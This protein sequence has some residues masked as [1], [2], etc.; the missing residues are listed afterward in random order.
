[1]KRTVYELAGKDDRRFS[2]FC[3]RTRM[4][5]AHK[6]IDAEYE[7]CSFTEKHKV[8]FAEYDRYPVLVDGNRTVTDSWDIACYLEDT[9]PDRPSL[10]NG[11][12]G[13]GMARFV[14]SWTDTQLHPA[15]LRTVIFD[16][17]QHVA[18]ADIDY[19]RKDREA[20]FGQTLEEMRDQQRERA[21]EL[22][23]VLVPLR[24]VLAKQDWIS[25]EAPAYGDYIVFGALQWPRSISPFPVVEPGDPVHAWRDRIIALFDGLADSVPHYDY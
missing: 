11:P 9:Y 1:M 5:L 18:P 23:K 25:G 12:G 6:G 8:A 22:D 14:N 13:R 17:F 15:V 16:V 20:R 19:F 24:S 10:F 4:A 2:P 3:W 7:P 21:A